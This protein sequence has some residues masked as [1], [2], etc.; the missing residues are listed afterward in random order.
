M[1]V[2]PGSKGFAKML[3]RGTG[4]GESFVQKIEKS[5]AILGG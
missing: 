1:V 5:A 2:P 4:K 3:I